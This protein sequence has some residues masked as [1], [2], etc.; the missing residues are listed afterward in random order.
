[1]SEASTIHELPSDRSEIKVEI[2]AMASLMY[3]LVTHG[4]SGPIRLAV[5]FSPRCEGD[6]LCLIHR[7]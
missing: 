3:R 5:S 1:M 7:E 4:H 2:K 6:I